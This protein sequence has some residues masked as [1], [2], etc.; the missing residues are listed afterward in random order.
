M[1]IRVVFAGCAEKIQAIKFL[2][3]I[4]GFS[5][6]DAKNMVDR[7]DTTDHKFPCNL[8]GEYRLQVDAV[9]ALTGLL[10]HLN[11]SEKGLPVGMNLYPEQIDI[12]DC[13]GNQQ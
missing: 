3:A 6:R 9:K 12:I 8:N 2:R 5:L 11:G 1:I 13:R 7:L 10:P 4:G